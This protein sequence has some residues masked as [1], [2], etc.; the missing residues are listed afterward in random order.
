MQ[1]TAREREREREALCLISVT[2]GDMQKNL[3]R[4]AYLQNTT[5]K[6]RQVDEP[7]VWKSSLL[8]ATF[9]STE[10]ENHLCKFLFWF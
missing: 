7:A 5:L 9:V 2:E 6:A 3:L 10:L 4:W 1:Q 8:T